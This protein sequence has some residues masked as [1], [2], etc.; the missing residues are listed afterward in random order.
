MLLFKKVKLFLVPLT[1]YLNLRNFLRISFVNRKQNHE[2][3]IAIQG[4]RDPLWLVLL[5]L[6][7]KSI[8][9]KTSINTHVLMVNGMS[10]AVGDNFSANLRRGFLLSF[11]FD[12]P[13]IITYKLLGVSVVYRS[14]GKVK[15]KW[16]KYH[17]QAEHYWNKLKN[18]SD[19]KSFEIDKIKVGDLIID[20]FI[21]FKPSASFNPDDPFVREIIAQSIIDIELAQKYFQNDRYKKIFL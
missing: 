12:I 1:I 14:T 13:W 7:A 5:V 18:T 15:L 16:K 6:V 2:G 20:S 11:I 8:S 19:I 21:R 3:T 9:L 17:K 10:R 4:L